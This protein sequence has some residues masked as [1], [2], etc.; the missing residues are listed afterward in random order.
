[1]KN[2]NIP[3]KI[4][5]DLA[6]LCGVITGDGSINYRENKKEY[7]IKCVGNPKDEKEFYSKILRPKIKIIFNCNVILKYHDSKTTYGFTIYS[8]KLFEYL[9]NII[10]LPYGKKYDK[11]S[12]PKIFLCKNEFVNNFIKGLYDTDGCISFKKKHKEKPYYPVITLSS[13]NKELIKSVSS[14]LKIYKL[15]PVEIYDYK[16]KDLRVQLGYTIINRI[17]LN[18]KT[19]L[20]IWNNEFGFLNPKHLAK[21]KK[22]EEIK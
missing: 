16:V 2:I 7:S 17:E 10:K 22:Y 20:N 1:M 5:N 12:I 3:S 8:K 19:N 6:Y 13:K 18:G 15:K 14:F 11:L 21:I 4:N 9:T